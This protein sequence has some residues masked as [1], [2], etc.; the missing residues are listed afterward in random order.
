[1][2][3]PFLLFPLIVRFLVYTQKQHSLCDICNEMSP[4]TLLSKKRFSKRPDNSSKINSKCRHSILLIV[5][6]FWLFCHMLTYLICILPLKKNTL[7]GNET[8]SRALRRKYPYQTQFGFYLWF[9]WMIL[10]VARASCL[11]L[12]CFWDCDS[13]A[14]CWNV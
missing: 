3:N 11:E 6:E 2:I 1:M 8:T 9:T 5:H 4:Q 14:A 7:L 13:F 10:F 12:R